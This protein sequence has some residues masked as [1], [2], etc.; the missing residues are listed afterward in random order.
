MSVAAVG[1]LNQD[2]VVD[3]AVGADIQDDGGGGSGCVYLL[4]PGLQTL[5]HTGFIMF[6]I[7]L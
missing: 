4:Y 3:L 5:R 7:L 2:G 1:D 6:V